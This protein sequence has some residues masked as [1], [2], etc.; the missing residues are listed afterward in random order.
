[1][2]KI[3]KFVARLESIQTHMLFLKMR[4]PMFPKIS[5]GHNSNFRHFPVAQFTYM[6]NKQ[7][8]I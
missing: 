2:K 6:I 3:K 7:L 8:F 5:F 1:M 4:R